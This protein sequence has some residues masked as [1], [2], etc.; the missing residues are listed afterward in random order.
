MD[1]VHMELGSEPIRTNDTY[2]GAQAQKQAFWEAVKKRIHA[3]LGAVK[4]AIEAI[5]WYHGPVKHAS[6]EPFIYILL[7]W[8]KSY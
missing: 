3:D 1:K 8:H 6:G 2:P 7:K 4:T 5:K